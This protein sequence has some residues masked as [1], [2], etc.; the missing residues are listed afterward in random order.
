MQIITSTNK[1][2]RPRFHLLFQCNLCHRSGHD[3]F[4]VRPVQSQIGTFRSV[5]LDRFPITVQRYCRPLVRC[6]LQIR[7]H[8]FSVVMFS[9]GVLITSSWGGQARILIRLHRCVW[10]EIW[11]WG[12][13]NTSFFKLCQNRHMTSFNEGS[14]RGKY[15][16]LPTLGKMREWNEEMQE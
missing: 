16:Y 12:G 14:V 8:M 5:E 13:S 2:Q 4:T 11:A 3:P 7:L 9:S 10:S 6:S 1:W 15:R